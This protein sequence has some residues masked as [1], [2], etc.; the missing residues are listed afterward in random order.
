MPTAQP[1]PAAEHADETE[2]TDR[3]DRLEQLIAEGRRPPSR[4]DP[5]ADETGSP[6]GP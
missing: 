1:L 3:S 4:K 2:R 5:F 6:E